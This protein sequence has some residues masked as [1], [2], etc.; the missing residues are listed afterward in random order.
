LVYCPTCQLLSW[1]LVTWSL[2]MESLQPLEDIFTSLI[3]RSQHKWKSISLLDCQKT[4]QLVLI[5]IVSVYVTRFQKIN[6]FVTFAWNFCFEKKFNLW[7]CGEFLTYDQSNFDCL[8]F[9]LKGFFC[10]VRGCYTHY[11]EGS[12]IGKIVGDIWYNINHIPCY[13]SSSYYIPC[14]ITF[15]LNLFIFLHIPGIPPISPPLPPLHKIF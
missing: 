15:W 6:H 12:I 5:Q 3:P 8:V 9:V 10:S 2:L 4:E 13:F 1:T 7:G 11:Y 14:L